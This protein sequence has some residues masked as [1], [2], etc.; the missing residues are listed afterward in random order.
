MAHH[1]D[2]AGIEPPVIGTALARVLGLGP[3][4]R[5]AQL[6]GIGIGRAISRGR[7][8]VGGNVGLPFYHLRP[9]RTDR[10]HQI[11]PARNF[12][13]EIAEA[14]AIIGAGAIAPG[15]DRQLAD[16]AGRSQIA[17]AIDGV[18]GE[19]RIADHFGLEPMF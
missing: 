14:I 3:V 9:A 17:R 15:D 12:G 1:R 6:R 5:I 16:A 10:Q 19:R 8:G 11:T 18:G 7:R 13:E 2:R 4:D